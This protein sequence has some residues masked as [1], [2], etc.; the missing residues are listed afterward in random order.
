MTVMPDP[1]PKSRRRWFRFSLRSMFVVVT[2]LA[3]IAAFVA[4]NLNWIRQR[5]EMT[6]AGRIT[7]PG[8]FVVGSD[9][10]NAP[11]MLWVFGE[12]GY[13]R[14]RVAFRDYPDEENLTPEQR[15]KLKRIRELY[16]EADITVVPPYTGMPL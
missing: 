3:V 1:T 14:M 7:S 11:G 2:V 9:E 4:Y 12:R 10:G 5:H 15:L 13:D 6:F 8:Y 16:P